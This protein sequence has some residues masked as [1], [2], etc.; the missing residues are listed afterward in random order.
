MYLTKEKKAEIAKKMTGDEKNTGDSRTQIA[1]FTERINHL[2][3]HL[4]KNKKD[5]VT[6]RSLVLLVGKRRKLLDYLKRKNF[7]EYRKIL[8]ELSLRR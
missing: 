2:T 8:E 1:I 4:K 3:E 5:K 7:E 6:E